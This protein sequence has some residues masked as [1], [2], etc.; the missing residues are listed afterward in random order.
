MT[1]PPVYTL[2]IAFASLVAPKRAVFEWAYIMVIKPFSLK[3]LLT[4]LTLPFLSRWT[5]LSR[6]SPFRH[7]VVY[8]V[9]D[10]CSL[11]QKSIHHERENTMPHVFSSILVLNGRLFLR[12]SIVWRQICWVDYG[13]RFE[14]L[15]S[16]NKSTFAL[17]KR[18]SVLNCTKNLLVSSTP[19][20]IKCLVTK[21]RTKRTFI[22]WCCM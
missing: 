4:G 3:E 13:T 14:E 5:S 10:G 11:R 12:C 20:Q 8:S 16:E 18:W 9:D 21:L 2:I 15:M 17:R 1:T 7:K 19:S 6:E 22:R